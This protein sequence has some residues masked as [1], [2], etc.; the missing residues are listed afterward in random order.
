MWDCYFADLLYLSTDLLSGKGVPVLVA[1]VTLPIDPNLLGTMILLGAFLGAL[2]TVFQARRMVPSTPLIWANRSAQLA[3]SCFLSLSLFFKVAPS[4]SLAVIP[5]FFT[6]VLYVPDK[7]VSQFVLFTLSCAT[8][9]LSLLFEE[10]VHPVRHAP[11]PA[12]HA[13]RELMALPPLDGRDYL[14]HHEHPHNKSVPHNL[15]YS[16]VVFF[17]TVYATVQHGP[18]EPRR[19]LS[20][21]FVVNPVY[22]LWPSLSAA[23][24]RAY[25][26]MRVAWVHTNTL[27]LVVE[28]KDH[29][30]SGFLLTLL[31]FSAAWNGTLL[32][33]QAL[34]YWPGDLVDRRMRVTAAVVALAHFFSWRDA[35]VGYGLVL[36]FAVFSLATSVL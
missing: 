36:A 17:L 31:L 14:V 22:S 4:P 23:L 2:W 35:W 13:Q 15:L 6:S 1:A 26:L 8:L 34:T 30:S 11:R 9:I 25:L 29:Q 20:V 16:L 5:L 24:L 32:A 10:D 27:H 28:G 12:Y 3:F 21:E 7:K 33:D 19:N 18:L